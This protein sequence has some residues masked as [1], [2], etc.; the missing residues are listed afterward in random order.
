MID[1]SALLRGLENLPHLV[2]LVN[3]IEQFYQL[4]DELVAGQTYLDGHLKVRVPS[5]E[6]DRSM[7]SSPEAEPREKSCGVMQRVVAVAVLQYLSFEVRFFFIVIQY[8]Q[9]V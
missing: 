2:R 5:Y 9:L 6:K 1:N 4:P 8:G 3:V 7:F